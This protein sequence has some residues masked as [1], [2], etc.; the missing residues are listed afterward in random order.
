MPLLNLVLPRVPAAKMNCSNP[1]TNKKFYE[2][3]IPYSITKY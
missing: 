2:N 1:V 3:A